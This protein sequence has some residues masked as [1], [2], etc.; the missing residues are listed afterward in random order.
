M[1]FTPGKPNF[2]HDR[3]RS[4]EPSLIVGFADDGVGNPFPVYDPAER[5]LRT[6]RS[7]HG[8]DAVGRR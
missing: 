6:R 1:C 2:P 5:T 3:S 4:S 7:T 8:R